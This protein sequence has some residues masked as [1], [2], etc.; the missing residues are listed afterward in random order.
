M[1]TGPEWTIVA[2][3]GADVPRLK[4]EGIGEDLLGV[5]LAPNLRDLR[6]IMPAQLTDKHE[7][8]AHGFQLLAFVQN[9][10]LNA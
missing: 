9:K 6:H 3:D 5:T 8:L 1:I 2:S 10:E 7:T 4:C